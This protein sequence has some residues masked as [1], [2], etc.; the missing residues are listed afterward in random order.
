[1]LQVNAF[2]VVG[3][4]SAE[5]SAHCRI[6]KNSGNAAVEGAID[7]TQQVYQCYNYV[8]AYSQLVGLDLVSK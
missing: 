6:T 8:T 1:M 3:V 7:F 2:L 4:V 5:R